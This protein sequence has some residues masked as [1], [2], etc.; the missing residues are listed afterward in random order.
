M[1]GSVPQ[2]IA[3]N[4]QMTCP[5]PLTLG[6]DYT[7]ENDWSK[8]DHVKTWKAGLVLTH[9]LFGIQCFR[10]IAGHK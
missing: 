4:S 9:G 7:W 6:L 3:M 8:L 1:N 5:D 10:L 2:N